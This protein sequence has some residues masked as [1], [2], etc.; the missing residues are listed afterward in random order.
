MIFRI[1]Y[2]LKLI[3]LIRFRK[4]VKK[5]KIPFAIKNQLDKGRGSS[6]KYDFYDKV[7]R[8]FIK[9]DLFGF[10]ERKNQELNNYN[11]ISSRN[12]ESPLRIIN[13]LSKWMKEHYVK[14]L[15]K[16]GKQTVDFI[17]ENVEK[18]NTLIL[19]VLKYS[20]IDKLKKEC[21]EVNL[22]VLIDY[23]RAH[24]NNQ[25]MFKFRLQETIPS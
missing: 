8:Q 25:K 20:I 23:F 2:S 19:R 7:D 14:A 22:N 3:A 11:H 1:S 10:F 24:L 9:I 5:V 13:A 15:V 16:Y 12:L 17:G 4:V 21:Y 18:K 6:L